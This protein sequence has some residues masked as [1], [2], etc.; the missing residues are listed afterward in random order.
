[1]S[2]RY[3]AAILTASYF[4]LKT[5]SAPTI[6][7]ATQASGTSVSVT[8][9]APTDIGGGAI[10]SYIAIA[11]DSSSGAVFTATGAS[12]PITVT[13]L[14]TTN[15]YTVT[16]SATNAFGTGPASAS[17]NAIT[18]AIQGQ[19]AFTTSGS[20]SW[21]APSGV[22]SVSVVVVGGGGGAKQ[23]QGP[24]YGGSG[25]G[26]GA[27]AYVNNITVTPGN[28]YNLYVAPGGVSNGIND[29]V[30]ATAGGDS[31]F[32]NAG[33]VCAGGGSPG[34]L[35]Y[36]GSGGT[37]IA[38]TGGIGG[39]GGNRAGVNRWGFGGGAGGY[40]G[41]GGN[42][43]Q[44]SG[45]FGNVAGTSGS[46]GAAGGANDAGNSGFDERCG[47]GILGQGASGAAGQG[48]SGGSGTTGEYGGGASPNGG[49]PSNPSNG[50]VGA[51]RI[52]WGA[53]RA[54]PSTNT[55]DL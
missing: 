31:Y 5:P 45:S 32:I 40:A 16:V 37:L 54:F 8:F 28:S 50:A 1:M 22:T 38:G 49:T 48:G 18:L 6:G 7:T 33:T 41:A 53:G 23:Y 19:Q 47:V 34:D 52:I 51:V 44:W 10:T 30:S 4:P 13:G 3:Q 15:T 42:G 14:T 25:G 2:M 21:V 55:G 9:T 43:G 17:S 29:S 35:Y 46:G 39:I 24:P 26:G 20:Y 11:K 36:G 12:S 27:L